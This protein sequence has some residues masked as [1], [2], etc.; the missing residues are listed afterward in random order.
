MQVKRLSV[1]LAGIPI[2]AIYTSPL[3]RAVETADEIAIPHNLRPIHDQALGEMRFGD[4]EGK[5]FSE[6][7]CDEMWQG[8]NQVRSM[9][10]P[11]NGELMIAVQARMLEAANRMRGAHQDAV[12]ALVSHADPLRALIACFMGVAL[13]HLQRLRLDPASV[14]IVR[15]NGRWL[16]VAAL[17]YTGSV[18]I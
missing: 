15:C 8:F 17:N 4:W 6:L 2:R 7:E 10:R 5:T 11:P 9:V 12:I 18:T 16:E 13:D 14:S 3:E 1:I